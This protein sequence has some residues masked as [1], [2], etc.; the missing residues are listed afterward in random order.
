MIREAIKHVVEG[1]DLTYPA[2]RAVMH[3]MMLGK[4]TPGQIAAFLTAM[5][6]KGER[7]HEMLGFIS[8]MLDNALRIPSPPGAVDVCGTGGDNSGTFN[9]STVASFVVSATGVP[10]AK[11]GNRSVSSRCGSADLLRATGIPF[12]LDPPYVERCL[13]EVGLGFLFA[14]TFH[15]LMKSVNATR[16]EI[17]IPTLFNVLGP[18]ANPANPPYRLIGVYKPSVVQTVANILRSLEVHHALVVHGNGLDEITNTGETIVVELKENKI[19]GYSI[20]PSEFGIDLA[21]PNEIIGGDPFENAR[22][23]MSVLRGESN[24][25]LDLVLLNAGAALYVANR[26]ENIEE[27]IKIARKAITSGRALSKFKAFH[28]FVNELEVERQRTM[29]I[30]SLRKT[31]ICPES[32]VCRCQ[33]LTR[34]MAKEIMMSER[35]AYLLKGLDDNLFK[36]PGALT[37][38]ILTKILRLLSE[39]KLN[40]SLQPRFNRASRQKMSDAIL[41][42]EGLAILGEFKNRIPS[43]KNLYIPPEPSLIAELYNSYGLDGMSVVVEEDFFFGHPNLFTFFRERIDIPMLFKDFIVSEEQ[44]R[45]AA[46]LGANSIL[47]ISKALKKDRI[48]TLIQES[49]QFGLEPII[50]VHDAGDVEKI[51]TCSNYDIISLVGIN[52]RNLQTLGTDLSMLQHL[53]KMITGDKL[54][55]AE[56]GIMESKDLESLQGFDA[57]LIGSSF[58]TAERPADKI[59]DIVTAA[60]RM[61]N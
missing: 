51:I 36:S 38:I 37:V 13:F 6:M 30:D 56:S 23:A 35:G 25:K 14:P 15:V 16:K 18:L 11:H 17:G 31:V 43:S 32:L 1:Y 34:E 55:I 54:L 48:E 50:E 49:I 26:A 58:L 5:K 27:G 60:R 44:I 12:D 41:N 20:S 4:A 21:E 53:K 39:G 3:E 22:I 46:E 29:S 9:V 7:E 10:V 40:I 28:S 59:A 33:D 45:V 8:E 57:A 42:A 47:I 24:P 19:F 2:A 52:S 61:K